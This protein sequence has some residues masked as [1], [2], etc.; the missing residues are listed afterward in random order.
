[1]KGYWLWVV[2]VCIFM[3][4][5]L[6]FYILLRPRLGAFFC[7]NCGFRNVFPTSK[8]RN[9]NIEVN[10]ESNLTI[11]GEWNMADVIA[12][13]VLSVFTLPISLAGL[14]VVLGI[15]ER[16]S[17][18]WMTNFSF[19]FVGT[20]LLLILPFWFITIV[21]RRS[22]KDVGLSRKRLYRNIGFGIL[23]VIPVLFL[24]YFS[25]EIIVRAIINTVPTKTEAIGEF[26]A[27]EHKRGAELW[28]ENPDEIL[29]LVS[30]GFLLVVM[31]PLGEEILFR[32]MAYNALRKRSRRRALIV[33]SLLFAIAHAQ[34]IHFIPVFLTGL[35]MAYLYEYTRSLIPAITLHSLINLLLM[36]FWYYKTGLYT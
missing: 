26:V 11:H 23:A 4:F 9:C 13:F 28:P 24:S 21:C 2:G 18:S 34:V 14:S 15:S 35:A 27:E 30:A 12:L 25:E 16:D 17:T 5:F 3:P 6:P 8:C 19:S 7:S 22:L 29:K 1:M 31:G 32:G 10:Q 36:I 20:S 33:T